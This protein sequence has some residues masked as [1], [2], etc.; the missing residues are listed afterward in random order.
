MLGLLL[1]REPGA[2]MLVYAAGAL[3]GMFLGRGILHFTMDGYE[4]VEGYKDPEWASAS[5][6]VTY[7]SI[8]LVLL[9][10]LLISKFMWSVALVAVIAAAVWWMLGF[11]FEAAGSAGV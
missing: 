5:T 8:G 10:I 7:S 6:G 11:F 3:A 1:A 4:D 9:A 2:W